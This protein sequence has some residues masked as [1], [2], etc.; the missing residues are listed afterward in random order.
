MTARDTFFDIITPAH[1]YAGALVFLVLTFVT[2][3]VIYTFLHIRKKRFRAKE[4]LNDELDDWISYLLS[5]DADT[6]ITTPPAIAKYMGKENTRQLIIDK[7]VTI[8][9]NIT[10]FGSHNI[11]RAYIELGL[12]KD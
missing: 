8:K 4:R 9:K 5:E 12:L 10:G 3:S 7:L 6:A 11:E 1:L 2:V